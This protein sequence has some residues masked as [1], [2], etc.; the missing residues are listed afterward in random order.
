VFGGAGVAVPLD[1]SGVLAALEARAARAAGLASALGHLGWGLAVAGAATALSHVDG[2]A[3]EW[4]AVLLL[5]IVALGEPVASLPD[6]AVARRR[7]AAADR[8]IAELATEPT[9]THYPSSA[10]TG[11]VT[12][13]IDA[14]AGGAKPSNAVFAAAAGAPQPVN[15]AV[16]AVSPPAPD[17]AASSW[18]DVAVR[19]LV[20]GW[21]PERAPAL[22]GL[23]L[24]LSAGSRVAVLGASGSGKSTLAAVL[25][26][27]LDQR[28]GTVTVGGTDLRR[29]PD[30]LIRRRIGLVSDDA[31]HV[32][33]STVRENLRLAR[34]DAGDVELAH[35]LGRVG[36]GDWPLSRRL[37]SGGTTM[38]GGQRKRFATA[39]ALLADPALL[40]LDEPTEG[41]D[42][43]AAEALM[44]DL[45]DAS[46]GR[47]VLLLTHRTEGL[48][49]VDRI[50]EIAA[51][52]TRTLT[53]AEA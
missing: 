46:A 52:R 9:G 48:N 43:P 42:E 37:G 22:R 53:T 3:P 38:S 45:L 36:L 15:A 8:R 1:R 19:G 44:A 13:A 25:A 51:G 40:I 33:A 31:D 23:D 4:A 49:R 28:A 17:D 47:T 6:A 30:A 20:A 10:A 27:L 24:D 29:L 7:A 12:A 21:D 50:L 11:P 14:A 2:L 41:L 18:G 26:R 35:A 34:P 16:D 32:F 5:G 39:R